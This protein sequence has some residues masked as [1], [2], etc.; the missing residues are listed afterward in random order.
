[1]TGCH[2]LEVCA[3]PL[4]DAPEVWPRQRQA[5]STDSGDDVAAV[6]RLRCSSGHGQVFLPGLGR[7]VPSWAGDIQ[8][9]LLSGRSLGCLIAPKMG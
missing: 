6:S 9:T 7:Q 4:W 3:L 8:K 2:A 1:M 5:Q